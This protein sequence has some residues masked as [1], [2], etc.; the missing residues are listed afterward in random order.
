MEGGGRKFR[1]RF[2]I[3]SGRADKK[4]ITAHVEEKLDLDEIAGNLYEPILFEPLF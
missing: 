2:C 4:Y 3:G 1:I